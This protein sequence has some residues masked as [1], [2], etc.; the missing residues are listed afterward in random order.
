MARNTA[1]EAPSPG[2][3]GVRVGEMDAHKCQTATP[4]ETWATASSCLNH[5]QFGLI[6]AVTG[7]DESR[8]AFSLYC[9][10]MLGIDGVVRV[11]ENVQLCSRVS[12]LWHSTEQVVLVRP[13]VVSGCCQ[14]F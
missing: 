7:D 12:K 14:F 9:T 13:Q 6:A 8:C 4:L 10:G 5:W 11:F 1:Q 2:A 3:D